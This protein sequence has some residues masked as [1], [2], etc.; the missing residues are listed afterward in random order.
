MDSPAR[1]LNVTPRIDVLRVLLVML[2]TTLPLV[3]HESHL[4]L[5]AS[6]RTGLSAASPLRLEIDFDGTLALEGRTL[7]LAA[8]EQRLAQV[9][10]L[11]PAPALR[12]EPDRRTP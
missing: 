9:A 12:I 10:A 1:E 6:P 11:A 2:I 3:T 5:P 8:L 4:A 7:G